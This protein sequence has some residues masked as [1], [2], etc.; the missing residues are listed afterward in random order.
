MGVQNKVANTLS[1]CVDLLITLNN[2]IV[3]FKLLKDL[4][5]TDEDF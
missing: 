3:G 1:H 5:D 2:E 4:Y